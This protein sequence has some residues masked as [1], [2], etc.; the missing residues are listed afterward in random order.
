MSTVVFSYGR[1]NPITI[2]HSVLVDSLVQIAKDHKVDPLLILTKTND[3]SNPLTPDQKLKWAE[4]FYPSLDIE[5]S[6]EN[7]FQ[8]IDGFKKD[9][10]DEIILVVGSDRVKEFSDRL[11]VDT[12]VKVVSGG[13]R[14]NSDTP[15]GA[16]ATKMREAVSKD[17][18]EEFIELCP[19][20]L[21]DEALANYFVDIKTGLDKFK[22]KSTK[23]NECVKTIMGDI[24]EIVDKRTNYILGINES[25][26]FQKWF[27]DQVSSTDQTVR[28][29]AG[30]FKGIRIPYE[31]SESELDVMYR[32]DSYATLKY[33]IGINEGVDSS[34]SLDRILEVATTQAQNSA[35]DLIAGTF[36]VK[37]VQS[38]DPKK[39]LDDLQKKIKTKPMDQ[40]KKSLYNKML[41]SLGDLDL[42]VS[43][44][45]TAIK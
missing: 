15:K 29:T 40:E 23:K 37:T 12:T 6:G 13:T 14:D 43:L 18:I 5:I 11:K 20:H 17:E 41:N 24:L 3:K 28:Y 21:G 26:E 42:P 19:G 32:L 4:T 45:Q 9:S 27:N 1:M 31:I 10:A 44:D 33:I 25:G 16:S 34:E 2:G 39:K 38:T 36:D 7:L 30:T 35:V 8:I 22:S